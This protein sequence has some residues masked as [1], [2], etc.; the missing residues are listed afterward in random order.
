MNA[1]ELRNKLSEIYKKNSSVPYLSEETKQE[2]FKLGLLT[3]EDGSILSDDYY[4][5]EALDFA[6]R[7]LGLVTTNESHTMENK[8]K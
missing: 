3:E 6:I 8:E 7:V 4:D 2:L 5:Q 1:T